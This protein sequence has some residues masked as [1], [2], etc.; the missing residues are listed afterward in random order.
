MNNDISGMFDIQFDESDLEYYNK[1]KIE[2]NKEMR[3]QFANAR[4]IA[5]LDHCYIC[6]KK[7]NKFCKSH[8]VPQFCLRPVA[9]NGKVQFSAMQRFFPPMGEDR[10][11]GEAGTFQLICNDCD[12]TLFQ[13]YENPS[14]Y[15]S[16]PT[17]KMLAQIAMKNYLQM[18]SKR[19]NEIALT[20]EICR[21]HPEKMYLLDSHVKTY[22]Y[23]LKEYVKSCDRAQ[24]AA[25]GGHDDWFH[26]GYYKKLDY[27]VPFAVQAPII[28]IS[29]FEDHIVN[30][31][32]LM[33]EKL[34]DLHIAI[35][36]LASS[37]V[38]ILFTDNKGKK[39]R[40][41]FKQLNQLGLEDQLATVNYIVHSYTENVFLS[42]VIDEKVFDNPTFQEICKRIASP[43]FVGAETLS[44][45]L[46]ITKYS[47]TRRNEIPN[48]LSREY[49]LPS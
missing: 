12:N 17:G 39:Y 23:D 14:A 24:K 40:K 37:S 20:L 10:G 45:Q 3:S 26:I 43:G 44:L 29:D 41:F 21:T 6:K 36:P 11:V 8:S 7:C 46:A 18:I 19:R 22:A 13:D 35:F 34:Q 38:V 31:I 32:Y 49:S 48:L 9:T 5:K 42:K 2:V 27:V 33:T 30:N 4:K 15:D 16:Y 25:K 1:H 28:L 47:L